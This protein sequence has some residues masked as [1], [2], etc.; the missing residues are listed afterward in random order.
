MFVRLAMVL[1][2]MVGVV[3]VMRVVAVVLSLLLNVSDDLVVSPMCVW[4]HS[5]SRCRC[6]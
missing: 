6:I 5:R 1:M 2:M 4:V 3:R